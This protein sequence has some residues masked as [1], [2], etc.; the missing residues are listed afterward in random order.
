MNTPFYRPQRLLT[1]SALLLIL[2]TAAL[3][4]SAQPI[5]CTNGD[6]N[7]D[8]RTDILWRNQLT[9][10]N[11]V[12]YMGGATH[13]EDQGI[14]AETD[15]DWQIVGTGNFGDSADLDIVWRNDRTGQNVAWSLSE[16]E[17]DGNITAYTPLPLPAEPDIAWAIV[18]AADFNR[19][20]RPDLLWQNSA[21]GQVRIWFMNGT[22]LS[23]V[24]NLG[25]EADLN[26][27]VVG[28]GD[29]NRDTRPDLVWRN[30]TTGQVRV[31]YVSQGTYQPSDPF[32]EVPN[33]SW[34]VVGVGDFTRLKLGQVV[35]E[36]DGSADILW[37][38]QLSGETALWVMQDT[39]VVATAY[40]P[41]VL[42]GAT[43]QTQA[44][45]SS[46][47]QTPGATSPWSAIA[48]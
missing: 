10:A 6:L 32:N 28:A 9:G 34:E 16:D 24:L 39:T 41:R 3:T 46:T 38:N 44:G 19:D 45:L 17:D 23:N 30:R 47:T 40:L 8:G 48:H 15:L 37:R 27:Q 33:L 21:T 36:A 13:L 2:A 14:P 11:T 22:A 35:G 26:W 31:W 20:T 42:D 7:C 25:T 4:S 43:L 5:S 29:F 1:A 12:W 18:A